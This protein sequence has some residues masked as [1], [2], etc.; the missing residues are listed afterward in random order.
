MNNLRWE[1]NIVARYCCLFYEQFKV[2]KKCL[3]HGK[4]TKQ[5]SPQGEWSSKTPCHCHVK[6]TLNELALVLM[7]G[8]P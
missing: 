7:V 1:Q 6:S 4:T 2:G 8:I 5:I 3:P